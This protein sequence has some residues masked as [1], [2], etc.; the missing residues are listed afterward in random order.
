MI[1]I[2]ALLEVLS[3]CD[4]VNIQL[5]PPDMAIIKPFISLC[6]PILFYSILFYSILLEDLMSSVAAIVVDM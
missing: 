4:V 1:H 2:A 6:C 3:C 5:I